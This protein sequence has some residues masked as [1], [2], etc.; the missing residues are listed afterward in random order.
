MLLLLFAAVIAQATYAYFTEPKAVMHIAGNRFEI[1][2]ADNERARTQGLSGTESLPADEA[3]LFVFDS[4]GKWSIWMKDMNY[5]IDVVW[6]DEAKKVVDFTT[7][8][9]PESYPKVFTPKVPARYIVEFRSGTVKELDIK[10]GQEAVFSG[11]DRE[12]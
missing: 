3:L 5:P 8:V 9:P 10:V 11:T 2:I 1:R 6:L 7:N 4:D 12:L